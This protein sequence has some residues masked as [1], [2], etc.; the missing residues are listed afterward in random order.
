MDIRSEK[1]F[2]T[3]M[4]LN[5]KHLEG[6]VEDENGKNIGFAEATLNVTDASF[7]IYG[8][9]IL[10]SV[11]DSYQERRLQVKG[12]LPQDIANKLRAEKS[13]NDF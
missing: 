9:L 2:Y 7:E 3:K 6:A 5:K 8:K 11:D 13:K 1:I 10:E 12:K 4:W